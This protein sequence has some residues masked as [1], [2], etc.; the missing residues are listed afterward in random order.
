MEDFIRFGS[1]HGC[2]VRTGALRSY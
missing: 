1:A 2:A